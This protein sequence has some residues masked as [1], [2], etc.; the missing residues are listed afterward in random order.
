MTLLASRVG[1]QKIVQLHA[2]PVPEHCPGGTETGSP[3]TMRPDEQGANSEFSETNSTPPGTRLGVTGL[4][5][6]DGQCE[7]NRG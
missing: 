6:F 4:E 3:R 5:H 1:L 2:D 7:A